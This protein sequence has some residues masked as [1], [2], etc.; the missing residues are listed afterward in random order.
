M[1]SQVQVVENGHEVAINSASCS[2]VAVRS[3]P[4]VGVTA[5]STPVHRQVTA[6]Q[7]GARGPQGPPG[8]PGPPGPLGGE[9]L[10]TFAVAESVWT[11]DHDLPSGTPTVQTFSADGDVIYGDVAFITPTQVQIAWFNPE[12]GFA[13]LSS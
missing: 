4:T 7:Q 11:C 13:R 8:P 10:F 1:S 12:T 5:L 2:V 3:A 9:E 6:Y